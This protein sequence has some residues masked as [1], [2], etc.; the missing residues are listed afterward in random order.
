MNINSKLQLVTII[1]VVLALSLVLYVTKVQYESLSAQSTA[2]YKESV[3]ERRKKELRSYIAVARGAINH[4]YQNDTIDKA[5]AQNLVKEI[6]ANM[7]FGKDGYFFAYDHQGTNLVL[8]G[9]EWRIGK[10]WID[11][12]DVNGIKIIQE[13]INNADKGG[14]YVEYIFHQPSK[15]GKLGKKLAYSEPLKKWNWMIGTGVYIDDIDIQTSLISQSIKQHIVSTSQIMLI[16]GL[17]SVVTVF[18]AGL[19]IRISENRL[20]NK[21]LRVLNER[22]FQTQE[23][24]CKRISREL[25]DGISQTAAATRFSLETIQLKLIRGLDSTVDLEQAIVNITKIMTDIRCISHQLHPGVLEDYGLGAALDELGQEFST[26]TN[27]QVDVVRLSVRN[28]LTSE[29]KTALYRITQEAFTNIERH[30]NATHVTV[31]LTLK[32]K[33]LVLK[34]EDNG[35]GFNFKAHQSTALPNEGIGLRNMKERLNFYHGKLTIKSDHNGT[36]IHACIAQSELRYNA[37]KQEEN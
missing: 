12:Q 36:T 3:I 32:D 29:V 17:F 18:A 14:G 37:D 6:L 7:T 22:I 34:I 27:I 21:K 11:M 30:S 8:P 33:W 25:H 13:L 15:N 24:E 31:S 19:F 35:D 9:Q 23:E 5:L 20:A 26:R 28:I 4:I 16:I 1:P 2:I 10:N